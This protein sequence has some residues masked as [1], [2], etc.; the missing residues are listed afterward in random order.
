ML[1]C[2]L[3]LAF[4]NNAII[5]AHVRKEKID[6]KAQAAQLSWCKKTESHMVQHDVHTRNLCII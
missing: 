3:I 2:T 1:A 5:R 6:S 4:F